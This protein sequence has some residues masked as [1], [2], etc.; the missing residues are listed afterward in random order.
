[1]FAKVNSYA[2]IRK[3]LYYNDQKVKVGHAEI[4]HAENFI[5]NV[6]EMTKKDLLTRFDQRISLN[7]RTVNPVAHISI[8]FKNADDIT[9]GQMKIL[10]D[11]YMEGIGFSEQPYIV[12][13]HYDVTQAHMHIIATNIREDGSRINMN[14]IIFWKSRQVADALADEYSLHRSTKVDINQ[15]HLFEVKEAQTIEYGKSST[16]RAI[17]DVLNTVVEHYKYE[18]MVELNAAF[19]LYNLTAYRGKELSH[20]Y[21][22]GGLLYQALDETGHRVGSP[23][24]ASRF[25]LKPTLPYLEKK[26]VENRTLKEA[27]RQHVGTAVEWVLAGS[28]KDWTGFVQSMEREGISVV[29]QRKEGRTEEVFFVDHREKSVHSGEGLGSQYSLSVLQQKVVQRVEQDE[30]TIQRHHLRLHL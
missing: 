25:F 9:N 26:F 17:S 21:K 6:G 24:K 12:Y 19:R 3:T 11:R 5:K 16:M 13:R 29:T 4:I 8:G 28:R 23:I 14:D 20:L 7:N 18:N 22:V 15:K 10:A 2:N 30:A 27:S 1:M